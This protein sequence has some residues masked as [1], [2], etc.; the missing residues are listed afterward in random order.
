MDK[1]I[2]VYS[3]A[4][5]MYEVVTQKTAWE[6]LNPREIQDCVLNNERPKFP[7]ETIKLFVGTNWVQMIEQGW[8]ADPAERPT[9]E[10]IQA[11]FIQ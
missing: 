8:A 7:D 9:F 10:N 4:I 6:G 3:F 11:Q 1:K 2:D 5:L